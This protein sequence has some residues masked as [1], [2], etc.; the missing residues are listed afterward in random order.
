MGGMKALM[1]MIG[2]KGGLEGMLGG[3]GG[4]LGGGQM[5]QLPPG[6]THKFGKK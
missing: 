6:M 4:Q 3:L 5:P 2:G 1:G